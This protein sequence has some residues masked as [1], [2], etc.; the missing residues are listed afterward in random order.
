[1]HRAKG[2]LTG[3]LAAVL[4]TVLPA[5][6]ASAAPL[7]DGSY[8]V[9]VDEATYTVEV[10][11]G[12]PTVAEAD[13]VAFGFV[14]DQTTGRVLDEFTLTVD[15]FTY[16]VA[17]A[18]DGS[19]TTERLDDGASEDD[20]PVVMGPS[21][22]DDSQDEPGGDEPAD[23]ELA[24][25]EDGL[26]EGAPLEGDDSE[27]DGGEDEADEGHGELV[28]TVAGCAPRGRTARD[29]GLPNHG[30]FVRAAAQGTTVDFEVDGETHTADFTTPEGA[31]AFCTLAEELLAA[32]QAD[33]A[34]TGDDGDAPGRSGDAPGQR[35]RGGES[36][37]DGEAEDDGDE[38]ADAA[39]DED[40][41]DEDRPDAP[42][43]SGDA[44]GRAKGKD[45][46][47]G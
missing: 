46:G 25:D 34:D 9:V 44:P 37:D 42:G 20:A 19:V 38:V 14:F 24:A 3:L 28:S 4:V 5:L 36:G 35:G 13:G 29:A 39:T 8:D 21:A 12:T 10:D 11:D 27:G 41:A 23:G 32:A 33:E 31:A 18:D 26:D 7:E 47:N 2:I 1:M 15:E 16:A 43:R 45:K 22:D 30:T 6:G 40:S 17:V